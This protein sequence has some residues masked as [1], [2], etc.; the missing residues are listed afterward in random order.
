MNCIADTDI[1]SA[2]GKAEGVDCLARLFDAMYITPSVFAEMSVASRM[3]F[4]FVDEITG[5]VHQLVLA[6]TET[7]E[8]SELR[9][10]H[11]SL[12]NGEIE[13]I[14]V[15]K[16]RSWICLTNDRQAKRLCERMDV[17]YL[18]LEELLRALYLKHIL[19]RAQLEDLIQRIEQ[20]D[21]MV[22]KARD[23]ILKSAE[24]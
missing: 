1:L 19:S 13:S 20:R 11:P 7:R 2:F 10:R 12:G 8:I 24:E 21:R 4:A 22:I 5:R 16:Q 18:D 15:A 6:E 17:V 14:V 9:H 23:E 3:G